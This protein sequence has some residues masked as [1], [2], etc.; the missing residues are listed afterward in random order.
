MEVSATTREPPAPFGVSGS[1]TK[2]I[3]HAF[4]ALDL[5]VLKLCDDAGI[6]FDAITDPSGRAPRD[7]A[8]R[9]WRAAIEASH[10][11]F[12]GLTAAEVWQTRLDH[13]VFL[14]LVSAETFGKGLETA[15]RFQELLAHG[16]VLSVADHPEHHAIQLHKVEYELPVLSHEVEF[17][18]AILVKLFRFATDGAFRLVEVQFQHPFRGNMAKYH[19]AF[20]APVRFGQRRTLLVIDDAIWNL[21][22]AHRNDTL[23]GQLREMAVPL[24][25][26]LH[27]TSFLDLVRERIRRLLPTGTC[28][29]ETVA[30]A[31]HMTPRTLQRRLHEERSSFR[32]LVDASR[33]AIVLDCVEQRRSP[34]EIL[35]SAGYTN[36]RSFRRALK[37]W[38]LEQGTSQST[39]HATPIGRGLDFY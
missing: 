31:L 29:V 28:G 20:G 32:A 30:A 27:D 23:H 5:D 14:L 36:T 19:N 7:A 37:R 3:V 24:H 25:H 21:A 35:R 26:G 38:K 4:R 15:V 8:G 39:D 18:A 33:K 11:R 13:L 34:D 12:L 16:R 10:D 1:W 9:L 2:G 22:P 6:D 17:L